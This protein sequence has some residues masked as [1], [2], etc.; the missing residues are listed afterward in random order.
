M[1]SAKRSCP[2]R[3]DSRFTSL[4]LCGECVKI[5]CPDAAAEQA[6]VL[7]FGAVWPPGVEKAVFIETEICE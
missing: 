3:H 6:D 2:V 1:K 5:D 4:R 7:D